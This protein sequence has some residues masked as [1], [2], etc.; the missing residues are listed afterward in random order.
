LYARPFVILLFFGSV[1]SAKLLLLAWVEPLARGS[2]EFKAF[3]DLTQRRNVTHANAV[4]WTKSNTFGAASS[5]SAPPP[6][7]PQALRLAP[8]TKS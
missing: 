4:G 3:T 2:G 7:A 5:R 6:S 8:P 1:N